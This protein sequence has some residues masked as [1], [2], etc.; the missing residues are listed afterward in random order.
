M[1]RTRMGLGYDIHRLVED[2]PLILGGVTIP[3]ELGLLGHSDADALFHA[4]ADALLGALA[5]GDLGRH[6]PDTDP[7]WEGADSARIL[8][9]VVA[10]V[11]E[12]GYRPAQVDANIIAQRPRLAPHIDDMRRNLARLLG[13][14]MDDVSVKART[15]EKLD[16]IGRCEGIAVQALVVVEAREE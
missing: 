7:A 5:L 14:A 8:A 6:F 9:R 16:A 1:A 15:A 13:L 10:M 3:F 4:V 2:R 12:R 11:A